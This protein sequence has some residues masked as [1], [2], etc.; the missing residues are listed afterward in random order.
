[1][2]ENMEIESRWGSFGEANEAWDTSRSLRG[3]TDLEIDDACMWYRHDFGLLPDDERMHLRIKAKEWLRAWC[4]VRDFVPPSETT[5]A[6]SDP[7][8][9]PALEGEP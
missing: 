2:S 1:M 4:K 3:P 7:V 5:S 8:I 9:E 6:L